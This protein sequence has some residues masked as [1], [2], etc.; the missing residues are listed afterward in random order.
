MRRFLG[1]CLLLLLS[2][3]PAYPSASD[4]DGSTSRV[5]VTSVSAINTPTTISVGCWTRREGDGEN[6]L[7][8][9]LNKRPSGVSEDWQIENDS[10]NGNYNVLIAFSS[11]GTI[12]YAV[13]RPSANVWVHV[14]F[15]YDGTTA[16]PVVYF[17]GIAQS[18]TPSA[19]PLGVYV[20]GT[21]NLV[22]GDRVAANRS[23][24]G[25]LAECFYYNRV[26][27][28]NEVKSI[29]HCGPKSVPNG[30][31]GYWPL[32]VFGGRNYTSTAGLTGTAIGVTAVGTGPPIPYIQGSTCE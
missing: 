8:Y 24:D 9:I 10:A 7:G 14:A 32:G 1:I 20:P 13:A 2:L 26:L 18:V 30:S 25:Q 3:T 28:A 11:P 4:F 16:D 12:N 22:I 17:D 29:R 21:G 5:E 27:G 15:T 19:T 31:V 6:S 23:W